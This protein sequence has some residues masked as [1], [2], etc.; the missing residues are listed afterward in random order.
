MFTLIIV[1]SQNDYITGTVL[2]KKSKDVIDEIKRFITKHKKE[3]CKI[4][5]ALEWHPYN[6]SSFKKYGGTQ[7]KH[8]IQHTPGA[9]IEPKLL[10]FIHSLDIDYSCSLRGEIEEV[11]EIGAFSDIQYACDNFGERY[12][13]DIVEV[14]ATSDFVICGIEEN[15]CISTIKN[16]LE[17]DLTPKVL[18]NGIACSDNGK[19]LN[20]FI[21]D[22]K[23]EKIV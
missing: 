19:L 9:C 13:L 23:L 7:Q 16:M 4:I 18:T 11:E 6:H 5:F 20:Q 17:A 3:I 1:N 2:V 10:K 12:Y 21:K 22:N 15:S 14:D 8:C